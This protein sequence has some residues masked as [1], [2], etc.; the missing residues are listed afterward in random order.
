MEYKYS[1]NNKFFDS[2]ELEDPQD[3]DLEEDYPEL[4]QQPKSVKSAKKV[5]TSASN[6]FQ[7]PGER[8]FYE[9]Q[10]LEQRKM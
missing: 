9:S 6:K 8:L 1:F 3:A 4:V 10:Q 2:E 7:A 5:T